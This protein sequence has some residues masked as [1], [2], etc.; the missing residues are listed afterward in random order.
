MASIGI[1]SFCSTDAIAILARSP[2]YT[3]WTLYWPSPNIGKTGNLRIN[4]AILFT[5]M[6]SLPKSSVGRVIEYG[7]PHSFKASSCALFP[8]NKAAANPAQGL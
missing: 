5:R 4:Q 8:G 1:I 6:S 2:T 7:T 3:G